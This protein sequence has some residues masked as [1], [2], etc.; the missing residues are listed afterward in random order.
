M[1]KFFTVLL[2][3][4]RL[5]LVTVLFLVQKTVSGVLSP[6]TVNHLSTFKNLITYTQDLTGAVELE[7]AARVAIAIVE[8]HVV[9]ALSVLL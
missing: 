4:P 8:V 6:L 1:N 9:R 5:R 3:P 2:F 7:A